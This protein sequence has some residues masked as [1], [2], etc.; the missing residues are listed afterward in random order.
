MAGFLC[1][2]DWPTGC[3]SIWSNILSLSVQV[4]LEELNIQMDRLSR[5]VGDPQI[6]KDNLWKVFSG[7]TDLLPENS[8]CPH[9]F[10]WGCW[11]FLLW[12]KMETLALPGS[13]ACWPLDKEPYRWLSPACWV[14]LSILR[15][16]HLHNGFGVVPYYRPSHWLCSSEVLTNTACWLVN[17]ISIGICSPLGIQPPRG[18]HFISTQLP[19]KL[20][21]D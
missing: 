21:I 3:P 6:R 1:P 10:T 2:L 7:T 5:L 8:S 15:L 16:A 19:H 17:G 18:G 9:V 14:T 12:A 11:H 13:W 20:C 4:V